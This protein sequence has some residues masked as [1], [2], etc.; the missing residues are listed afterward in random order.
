MASTSSTP[1]IYKSVTLAANEQFTLPPGAEI[2]SA[3]GGLDSF[4]STC[5]KPTSIETPGCYGFI[6]VAREPSGN[7]SRAY[8]ADDDLKYT[9]LYLNNT[10]YPFSSTFQFGSGTFVSSITSV[11][12]G[13]LLTNFCT[14]SSNDTSRN[15]IKAYIIFRTLPS[16]AKTLELRA[17][18]NSPNSGSGVPNVEFRIP[19]LLRDDI[20]N[21]GNNN[22]CSNC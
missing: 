14:S 9:G 11:P 8:D 7:E 15:S 1:C 3:T 10:Y 13:S 12:F 17:E 2:V 18:T 21:S 5:S 22:V 6:L 19:C 20:V 4:D 16:I